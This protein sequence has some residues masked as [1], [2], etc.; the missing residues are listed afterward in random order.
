MLSFR[1][2]LLAGTLVRSDSQEWCK[3]MPE[4]SHRLK[5]SWLQPRY[6]WLKDGRPKVPMFSEMKQAKTL[7]DM[8]EWEFCAA[9]DAR[10]H[11]RSLPDQEFE[12]NPGPDLGDWSLEEQADWGDDLQAS[13]LLERL[14]VQEAI[15]LQITPA[16]ARLMKDVSS[17]MTSQGLQ[18]DEH[19]RKRV[20][21]AN[22]KV[23]EATKALVKK[24]DTNFKARL[25]GASVMEA[26]ESIPLKV[27]KQTQ[28]K[29]AGQ[30]MKAGIQNQENIVHPMFYSAPVYYS[31][32]PPPVGVPLGRVDF[33]FI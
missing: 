15:R 29:S 3:D 33:F 13:E 16:K 19:T 31:A 32:P 20:A 18:A 30:K 27:G 17:L 25:Q 28:G 5:S 14:A 1:P 2:D 22:F 10:I 8:E 7:K 6:A 21:S 26:L 12:A 4:G 9:E 23:Q 24:H 11:L